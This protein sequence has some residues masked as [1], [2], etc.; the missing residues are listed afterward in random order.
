MFSV[1]ITR[2]IIDDSFDINEHTLFVKSHQ[3]LNL[4]VELHL[5]RSHFV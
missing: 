2:S 5:A 1:C 4:N 3:L